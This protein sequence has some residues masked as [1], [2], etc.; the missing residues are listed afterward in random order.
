[1]ASARAPCIELRSCGVGWM[2]DK[3]QLAF[4]LVRFLFAGDAGPERYSQA[5]VDKW[6]PESTEI[7]FLK[8][9]SSNSSNGLRCMPP[10]HF[11]QSGITEMRCVAHRQRL[12]STELRLVKKSA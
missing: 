9:F 11:Y 10:P 12:V 6:L 1:M 7:H 5:L 4:A 3:L 2:G 8:V